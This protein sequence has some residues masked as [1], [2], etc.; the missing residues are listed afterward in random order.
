MTTHA[1]HNKSP[2]EAEF[3][4]H[5][6]ASGVKSETRWRYMLIVRRFL[7]HIGDTRLERLSEDLTRS[8]FDGLKGKDRSNSA[9]AISQF[10]TFAMARLPVPVN[11]RGAESPRAAAP[12]KKELALRQKWTVEKLLDQKE[13]DDD[14]IAQLAGQLANHYIYFQS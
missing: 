6:K 10:L 4:K 12:T 7:K 9:T 11:A 3:R 5:L 14:V 13:T 8:F 2:I 1:P